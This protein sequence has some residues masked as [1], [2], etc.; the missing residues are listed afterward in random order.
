MN[1]RVRE[2]NPLEEVVFAQFRRN[3]TLIIQF[4]IPSTR[5]KLPAT[6]YTSQLLLD[7]PAQSFSVSSPIGIKYHIF[8]LSK[9]L[10]ILKLG[11][12]FNEMKGLI[13][14]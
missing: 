1:N 9:F 8:V 11:C 14:T 5:S 3:C 12:L 6:A 4:E 10:R 13:A 7:S 2:G